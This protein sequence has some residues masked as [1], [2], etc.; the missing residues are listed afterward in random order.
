M[1]IEPLD[2]AVRITL[3]DLLRPI[4][5][6]MA[7]KLEK[8]PLIQTAKDAGVVERQL[9]RM[10]LAMRVSLSLLRARRA[11]GLEDGAK[12]PALEEALLAL[13]AVQALAKEAAL[14]KGCIRPN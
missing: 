10:A 4:A 12:V 8:L 6:N 7:E 2:T 11:R 13:R 9:T 3:G 14:N 5:P 1:P